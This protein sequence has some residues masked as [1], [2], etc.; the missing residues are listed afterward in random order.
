MIIRCRLALS[1]RRIFSSSRRAAI[2]PR[3]IPGQPNK[4]T[5]SPRIAPMAMDDNN[6]NPSIKEL[7]NPMIVPTIMPIPNGFCRVR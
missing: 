3:I 4:H 7:E 2:W 6:G 5:E 1:A